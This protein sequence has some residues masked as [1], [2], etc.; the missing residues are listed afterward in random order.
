MSTTQICLCLNIYPYF[1]IYVNLKKILKRTYW[2]SLDEY[3]T[4][5]HLNDACLNQGLRG[6]KQLLSLLDPGGS[7]KYI[8]KVFD[9]SFYKRK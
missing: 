4:Q 7:R 5:K 2:L 8:L 9:Y 1:C 6:P 3:A